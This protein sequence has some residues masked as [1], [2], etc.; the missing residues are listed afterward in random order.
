MTP[1]FTRKEPGSQLCAARQPIVN[2]HGAVVGYEL[3]YRPG[4][5][6]HC[7]ACNHEQ[8]THAV[9][10]LARRYGVGFLCKGRPAFINCTRETLLSGAIQVLPNWHTVIEILETTPADALVLAACRRLK[11]LGYKIALDDYLPGDGREPLIEFADYIKADMR[12][13][14]AAEMQQIADAFRDSPAELLAEK[15]ETVEEFFFARKAGYRLFQ[16]RFFDFPEFLTA[17]PEKDRQEIALTEFNV[18]PKGAEVN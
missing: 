9:I 5:E 7:L 1:L 14:S 8:A 18:A 4:P 11:A 10:E 17:P 2:R 12:Q 16:G 3:L 13:A 15:V 6:N